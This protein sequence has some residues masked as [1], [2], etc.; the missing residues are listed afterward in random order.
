MQSSPEAGCY[1]LQ[2]CNVAMTMIMLDY[3]CLQGFM[4]TH[5]TNTDL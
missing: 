2:V 3:M 4:T 5:M 1:W